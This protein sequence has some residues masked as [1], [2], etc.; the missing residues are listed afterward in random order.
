MPKDERHR[1]YLSFMDRRGWHCQ[2]LEADLK[3]PLPRKLTFASPDKIVELVKRGG[4]FKDLADR[5]AF[6]HGIAI[7]RGGAYLN[8]TDEQYAAL[9]RR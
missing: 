4:G 7:G 2:F 3:T 9:K 5:Q 6:D 1:V 8:L